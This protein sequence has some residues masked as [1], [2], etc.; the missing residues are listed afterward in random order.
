MPPAYLL[1][2]PRRSSGSSSRHWPTKILASTM[3]FITCPRRRYRCRKVLSTRHDS[4]YFF[5]DQS[6]S[7]AVAAC[8]F[9]FEPFDRGLTTCALGTNGYSLSSSIGKKG[10][11]CVR[12]CETTGLSTGLCLSCCYQSEFHSIVP[13]ALMS[14][15]PNLPELH[16]LRASRHSACDSARFC[17]H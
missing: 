15:S 7:A 2:H 10:H 1:I 6:Q 11:G 16:P 14:K 5:S 4:Y 17:W 8:T 12:C 9:T 13:F 3:S